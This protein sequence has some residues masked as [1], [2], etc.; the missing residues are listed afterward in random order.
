MQPY[1]DKS[2]LITN[3]MSKK[4]L[5]GLLLGILNAGLPILLL[6]YTR[7]DLRSLVAS[8]M[9]LLFLSGVVSRK[10][11]INP[12]LLSV[13]LIFPLL[14]TFTLILS[15][16]PSLGYLIIPWLFSLLIGIFWDRLNFWKYSPLINA[17][18]VLMVSLIVTVYVIPSM[19]RTA[20]GHEVNEPSPAFEVSRLDGTPFFSDTLKGNV[21]VIDFFGTWCGPCQLELPELDKVREHFRDQKNIVF[22]IVDTDQPGDSR[23]KVILFKKEHK[24]KGDFFYDQ[25]GKTH[26]LFGFSGIPNLIVIDRN[27]RIRYKKEGYN[28][29]EGDFVNYMTN[30]IRK[31]G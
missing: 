3:R 4:I 30:L 21:I 9:I 20:L 14:I 31:M 16:L 8:A 10:W 26:K 18:S 25:G 29:A 23:E 19:V 7:Q 15:E 12:W 5:L 17:G 27:G 1:Q 11:R 2:S 28:S 13:L 6:F 22:L 24:F